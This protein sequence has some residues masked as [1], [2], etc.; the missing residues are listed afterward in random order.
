R[1]D[2]TSSDRGLEGDAGGTGER[3]GGDGDRGPTGTG[4]RSGS[5]TRGLNRLGQGPPRIRLQTAMRGGFPNRAAARRVESSR[6]ER[7][8]IARGIKTLSVVKCE[9]R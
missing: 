4:R 5:I 1:H 9:P 6:G 8:E 2:A 7:K 3:R